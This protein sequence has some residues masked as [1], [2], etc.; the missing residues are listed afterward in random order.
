MLAHH[1]QK[2]ETEA[3]DRATVPGTDGEGSQ[4]EGCPTADPGGITQP[5]WASVSNPCEMGAAALTTE[6]SGR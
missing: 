1:Q 3:G 5:L 4:W 2:R 6:P